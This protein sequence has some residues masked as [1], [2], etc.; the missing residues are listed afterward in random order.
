MQC[1]TANIQ[2]DKSAFWNNNRP[3]WQPYWIDGPHSRI[4]V[5]NHTKHHEN[6]FS[7]FWGMASDRL[8]DGRRRFLYPPLWTSGYNASHLLRGLVCKND[9]NIFKSQSLTYVFF[10]MFAFIDLRNFK[11]QFFYHSMLLGALGVA[12]QHGSALFLQYFRCQKY[13]KLRFLR[14]CSWS[15]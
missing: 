10:Y 7:S 13:A 3:S 15:I 11:N 12:R 5:Y 2:G 4:L 8:L 6:P 9:A 1:P 14:C